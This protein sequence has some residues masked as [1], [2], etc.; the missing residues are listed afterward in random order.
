[1]LLNDYIENFKYLSLIV[2]CCEQESF[3]EI[4]GLRQA[5]PLPG[6]H[7]EG[8]RGTPEQTH[9]SQK[10]PSQLKQSLR[11]A[12]ATPELHPLLVR[13]RRKLAAGLE[14]SPSDRART[15]APTVGSL[16]SNRGPA[17]FLIGWGYAVEG[18]R[19]TAPASWGARAPP[20]LSTWRPQGRGGRGR[21]A[22]LSIRPEAVQLCCCWWS[23][24]VSRP[25]GE[26]K[27]H[28]FC[29]KRRLWVLPLCL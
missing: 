14:P 19:E 7:P 13:R 26:F 20:L 28:F 21:Q 25:H 1:M 17:L 8:P 5:P 6:R 12:S 10:R 2:F 22:A 4:I 23:C 9:G 24:L 29:Q 27:E 16:L 18:C 15:S 11:R 3:V